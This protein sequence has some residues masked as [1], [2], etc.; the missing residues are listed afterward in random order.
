MAGT[1]W[2]KW[3][4]YTKIHIW[5]SKTKLRASK[6]TTKRINM[7]HCNAI[8]EENCTQG[9]HVYDYTST[10]MVTEAERFQVQDQLGNILSQKIMHIRFKIWCKYQL[11]AS[12]IFMHWCWLHTHLSHLLHPYCSVALRK[13]NSSRSSVTVFQS[14]YISIDWSCLPVI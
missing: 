9:S 3:H 13:F 1:K 5:S 8:N 4:S 12:D 11:S 14:Y 2:L 10:Y 6:I 7:W